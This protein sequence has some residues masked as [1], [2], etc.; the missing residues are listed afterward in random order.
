MRAP[1]PS[2]GDSRARLWEPTPPERKP[3]PREITV[4]AHRGGAP[5][6]LHDGE[7]DGVRVS[8]RP[9][10]EPFEPD[11]RRPVMLGGGELD[12]REGA[13]LE[14]VQRARRRSCAR[15]EEQE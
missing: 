7:A 13:R 1:W 4:E 14:P 9:A 10:S 11:P 12:D 2:C 6:R 5:R 15:P 3:R 8:D